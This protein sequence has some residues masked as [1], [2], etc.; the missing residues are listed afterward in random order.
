MHEHAAVASSAKH[1][2]NRAVRNYGPPVLLFLVAGAVLQTAAACTQLKEDPATSVPDAQSPDDSG[3]GD[4]PAGPPTDFYVDPNAPAPAFRTI[5]SAAAAA[6]ASTATARTIHVAAGNYTAGSGE[7]FPIEL[8]GI[9]LVGAGPAVTTITGAG[10]TTVGRPDV[11]PDTDVQLTLLIGD[12]SMSAT[13]AHLSIVSAD[14]SVAVGSEAI[15]CDRGNVHDAGPTIANTTIND[16]TFDGFDIGLRV[17]ASHVD[18]ASTGCS[19][20]VRAST[21]KDGSFG[22]FADG[23]TSNGKITQLV[24]VQVG[25]DSPGGGNT[26]RSL[27]VDDPHR[28]D[29]FA[30]GAAVATRAAV[31]G[32]EIKNNQIA[33]GDIGVWLRNP[34]NEPAIGAVIVGNDM[35]PLSN[36]GVAIWSN[37]V[38]SRLESNKIHG[39]SNAGT[40]QAWTGVGIEIDDF[41]TGILP[42][43]LHARNNVVFGND[44]GI[45]FRNHENVPVTSA[46]LSDFGTANDHGGNTIRCNGLADP[47]SKAG[48][49]G[50]PGADLLMSIVNPAAVTF[51]F[52]GNVWDHAP[53]VAST[54]ANVATGIDV[55]ANNAVVDV[56]N[57]ST[58][59]SPPCPGALPIGPAN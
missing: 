48:V 56:A 55:L 30:N 52:E 51:M 15:A 58:T 59:S 17:T 21:F 5:T 16:V 28:K 49:D 31:T 43:V 2:K 47:A 54:S 10:T 6:A 22:V 19:A 44:V 53:P 33:L 4:A 40:N 20:S 13:I 45:A 50:A 57:A 11:A 34:L 41:Y 26:F 38:V 39:V 7:K 8:R 32:I 25:D 36:T 27:K 35:G 37:V 23:A 12:S 46:N 1:A 24:A 14:A 3:A 29:V 9:S 42:S 18:D